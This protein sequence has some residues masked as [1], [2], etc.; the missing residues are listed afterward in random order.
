MS[1]PFFDVLTSTQTGV[2]QPE[3][4]ASSKS[5][6]EATSHNWSIRSRTLHGGRSEGVRVVSLD[7]TQINVDVLPTRGM[8]IWRAKAADIPVGWNSPVQNPVNP[9]FV[10][11]KD[12]NGLG[13]I[14]GFNELLC[15]CG[16]SFNGPPGIDE[17]A[18]STIESDVTIHGKIA[19]L[20]AHHV[21]VTA[22]ENIISV[23]GVVDEACLFGPQLR[24]TSTISIPHGTTQ[25]VVEDRIENFGAKSTELELLYHTNVGD[26]FLEG[27]SRFIAPIRSVSPRDARAAEDPE[28][29]G[30]YLP[31]T[32]GYAEQ[33]YFYE[34][35]GDDDQQTVTL[36]TNQEQ[37]LGFSVEF[38]LNQLP[39]FA[40]WKNTQAMQDGYCTGLEPATNF[41]NFKSFERD[42]GRVISLG[43]GEEYTSKIV[44]SVHLGNEDVQQVVRRITDLQDSTEPTIHKTPQPGISAAAE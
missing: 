23:K 19:N 35:I 24:M 25:I 17:G 26:P 40:Q 32:L 10:N 36:L 42:N 28:G 13:W 31:P 44:I 27:G 2:D 37:S 43:P 7:N 9:A 39:C 29:F 33:V 34:L 38:S 6:P 22:D 20:P 41:P 18:A 16:L 21:E 12:R 4:E 8:G 11:V 15:R 3:F 5:H 14:D 30:T 1:Q